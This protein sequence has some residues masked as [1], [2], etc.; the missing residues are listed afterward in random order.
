MACEAT[1]QSCVAYL[2]NNCG[3]RHG[4]SVSAQ[5][6]VAN[7][8]HSVWWCTASK[9]HVHQQQ[10]AMHR[11]PKQ[12]QAQRAISQAQLK[13]QAW[14]VCEP[15]F[16]KVFQL[17]QRLRS[18]MATAHVT[19]QLLTPCGLTST[20]L[21][22]PQLHCC[23]TQYLTSRLLSVHSNSFSNIRVEG[24]LMSTVTIR[25]SMHVR[26]LLMMYWLMYVAVRRQPSCRYFES[27]PK[28]VSG[29]CL[30]QRVMVGSLSRSCLQ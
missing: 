6:C 1:S 24:R 17:S 23:I 22:V 26:V 8:K 25:A 3:G 27:D 7:S 16:A 21:K 30:G 12:A 4:R 2:I 18:F 28:W 20:V 29:P 5:A 10:L 15:T 14:S 9:A 19:V 13:S 11:L